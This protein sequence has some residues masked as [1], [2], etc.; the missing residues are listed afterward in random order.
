LAPYSPGNHDLNGAGHN[1]ALLLARIGADLLCVKF[2]P[3]NTKD[4]FCM[5]DQSIPVFWVLFDDLVCFFLGPALGYLGLNLRSCQLHI[6][7]ILSKK[8]PRQNRGKVAG[9]RWGN[10]CWR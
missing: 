10:T 3:R 4:G 6:G 8:K 1:W 7:W 9:C 2:P 5:I